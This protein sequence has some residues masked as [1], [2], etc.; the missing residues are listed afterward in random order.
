MNKKDMHKKR[1]ADA[2]LLFVVSLDVLL[3]LSSLT[4]SVTQ[5]VQLST[6]YLTTSYYLYLVNRG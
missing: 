6:T 3:D 1:A 2:T 5:I 4:N